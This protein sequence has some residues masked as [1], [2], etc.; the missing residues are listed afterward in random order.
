MEKDYLFLA[1]RSLKPSSEFTFSANDYS[2]IQWDI[3]EGDAPS[4]SEINAEIQKIKTAEIAE[5]AQRQTAKA[6]LL[7]RLGITAEEAALLLA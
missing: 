2:T 4:Q 3:L 5:N 6:A 1:I 7:D